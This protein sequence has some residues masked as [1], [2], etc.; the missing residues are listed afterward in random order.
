MGTELQYPHYPI[1]QSY[2]PQ[3][4]DPLRP[5]EPKENPKDYMLATYK[6]VELVFEVNAATAIY[7]LD[8]FV[9]YLCAWRTEVSQD[10]L[11]AIKTRTQ[12][13]HPNLV[14]FLFFD[15]TSARGIRIFYEYLSLDVKQMIL[16]RA[17]SKSISISY[18]Q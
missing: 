6:C 16:K 14:S 10:E 11:G 5:R 15:Q 18:D 13:K 3:V 12:W 8:P 2:N 4:A 7:R 9:K 1:I 17:E